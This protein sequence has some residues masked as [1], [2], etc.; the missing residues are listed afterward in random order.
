M[1]LAQVVMR[2]LVT[3]ADPLHPAIHEMVRRV[4]TAFDPQQIMLFG[5][6]A[7][8]T[9]GPDSDADLLVVMD[10][11]GKRRVKVVELYGVIGAVGLPKDVFLVTPEELRHAEEGSIADT[12][13]R[14]GIVLHDR[15]RVRA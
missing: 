15:T 9:S 6:Y 8:G 13:L 10:F 5:S 11:E 1:P 3:R 4:V 2:G 12:A 7:K 14:E